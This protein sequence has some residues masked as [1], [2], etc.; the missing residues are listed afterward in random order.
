MSHRNIAILLF[1]IIISF[2]RFLFLLIPQFNKAVIF[3]SL[4][5]SFKLKLACTVPI[6]MPLLREM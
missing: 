4:L 3:I 1:L 6:A 5:C 2:S